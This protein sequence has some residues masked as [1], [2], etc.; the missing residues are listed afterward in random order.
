MF[1]HH[2]TTPLPHHHTTTM[3]T[4]KTALVTG[5]SQGIGLAVGRAFTAAGARVVFTSERPRDAVPDFDSVAHYVQAD[6]TRD[7]EPE[8]LVAAAWDLLGPIDVL[9][10]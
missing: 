9:V 2:L 8:R 1:F 5:S 10:N 3:L 6:L 7:G 4:G